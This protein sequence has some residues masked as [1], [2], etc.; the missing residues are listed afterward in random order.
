MATT[1][2]EIRALVEQLPPNYQ[3]QVLTIVQ[4]IARARQ[5]LAALPKTTPPPG[6]P[7]NVFLDLIS[8]LRFTPEDIEAM[9]RA[10]EDCE[11]E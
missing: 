2:E 9:E 4:E 10:L 7:S 5:A 1:A 3:Q 11:K 8:R 6:T